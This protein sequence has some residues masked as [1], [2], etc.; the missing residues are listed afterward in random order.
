MAQA[1]EQQARVASERVDVLPRQPQA[2]VVVGGGGGGGRVRVGG[3]VTDPRVEQAAVDQWE[4]VVVEAAH[5]GVQRGIGLPGE[6]PLDAVE[7]VK[8]QGATVG[9]QR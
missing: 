6:V 3:P 5:S 9:R 4:K 1:A 2:I 7:E 8:H